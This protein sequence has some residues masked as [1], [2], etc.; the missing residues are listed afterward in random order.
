VN[1]R[2]SPARADF[3]PGACE[4]GDTRQ[5]TETLGRHNGVLSCF[6]G[7][8]HCED[9]SFGPCQDGVLETVSVT[10]PSEASDLSLSSL[11]MP[12]ECVNNPCNPFC[13][14][15]VEIPDAGG[16]VNS[17]ELGP[18][19]S[20]T[21]QAGNLDD[22]PPG[23]VS[24][25]FD[26]PCE[27]GFDC[28]FDHRCHNPVTGSSCAHEKCETGAALNASCDSCVAD[29]CAVDSSCCSGAWTDT[30]VA[31]VESV[32]TTSCQALGSA[33]SCEPWQ[34]G[35]SDESC[36]GID[37][38]AQP[39]CDDG[40]PV[41]NRGNSTA[42][43]GVRLIHFPGNS[44]Q[45][46]QCNPGQTHPQ[47]RECFTT[48]AIGPGECIT[49]TGCTGLNGNREIMVNPPDPAGASVLYHLSE[50]S[51]RNNWSLRSNNVDCETPSCEDV[52]HT[53][54]AATGC[55]FE[56]P[57]SAVH[58]PSLLEVTLEQPATS[59]ASLPLSR[60]QGAADCDATHY[61]VTQLGATTTVSLCPAACTALTNASGASLEVNL[62][63]A[64][65][66]Y[67]ANTFRESY[68]ATC[69]SEQT[70]QWGFLAYD[71]TT[72]SDSSVTL[73]VRHGVDEA[74]LSSASF[75]DLLTVNAASANEA[76]P[77]SGPSP[78]PVDLFEL[79]EGA[80][81]AFAPYLELEFEVSPSSDA[82][83][84][85]LLSDWTVTY[86][87]VDGL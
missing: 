28:Q 65:P 80:P 41:C 75:E 57:P 4:P 67:T 72:P 13:Q 30:C 74:E 52:S 20:A 78:C 3:A 85:P 35:A 38:T 61:T 29:V 25:G 11:S 59:P 2:E 58:A 64:G 49:V 24:K 39:V 15:Y 10:L 27:S 44:M 71:F 31:L 83:E 12:S 9:G 6:V 54:T 34:L 26:E 51:C 60:A 21:W 84:A 14:E 36:S 70:S 82:S 40:I 63:C 53:Q 33:G 69:S 5:C 62:P 42:P 17:Y 7:V 48:E 8:Q 46:P 73:R 47:M 50:C 77:L 76:C 55:E 23:L 56:L 81:D 43:A 1:G 19:F 16:L 68:H 32:C 86:S 66:G 87:C 45:Y 18:S 37:L 22:F 79:L